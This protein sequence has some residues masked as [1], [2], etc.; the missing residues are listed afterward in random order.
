MNFRLIAWLSI[1]LFAPLF[2]AQ[3][4][5]AQTPPVQVE[6][7]HI[8]YTMGDLMPMHVTLTLPNEHTLDT[9][10]LPLE[11]RMRPWLDLRSVQYTQH[12][13]TLELSL[14]WQL[15]ATVEIAQS[16]K[17]PEIQLKTKGTKPVVI[18][19]PA[20]PFYYAPSF[21]FPLPEIKR[22]QNLPPF[23]FD[24]HRPK[25]GFYLSLSFALLA[26]FVW[27]WLKDLL[28]FFHLNQSPF[29]QLARQLNREH[30]SQ[31]LPHHLKSVHAAL[32][33]SAGMSLYPN[34]LHQLFDNAPYLN[35]EKLL[36]LLF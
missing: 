24:T 7:H 19:I 33:Q 36:L 21:A 6:M 29:T 2:V 23:L 30:P 26:L 13:Q 27:A 4:V 18:T 28:P 5:L 15:F 31:L 8:A 9:D 16:L 12:G 11:G 22:E 20:Q 17:T 3:S 1:W 35:A 25:M 14:V 34:T 10:S 32:N